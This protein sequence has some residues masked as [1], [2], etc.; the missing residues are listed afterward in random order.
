MMY[1]KNEIADTRITKAR[2]G[3]GMPA[4][5]KSAGS[6]MVM[7]NNLLGMAA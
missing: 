5:G 1:E 6:I 3:A 4:I 7:D 2:T